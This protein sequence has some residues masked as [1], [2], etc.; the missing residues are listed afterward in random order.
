M[1]RS[2]V[3]LASLFLSCVLPLALEAQPEP[4]RVE[5]LADGVFA[6]IRQSPF[7]GASDANV[8][9][10]VN[11]EDVVVV[12]AN[13]FPASSREVIAEIRKRTSKPVRYL[14]NT[15]FHSD[16]HYGNA[17]YVKAFPGVEIISHPRT[18]ALVISE[19]IPALARNRATVYPGERDRL[20]GMLASGKR[21]DG[22]TLA[23]TDSQRVTELITLYDFFLSDTEGMPIVPATVTVSDS[24]VLHRGDR[25]IVVR[26]L[27]RGNTPG[28][29]VVHLPVERIL[30]TG[31]LVVSPTPFG[32]GSFLREW[33]ATLRSL[34]T[35]GATTIVPGH[36]DIMTDWRY[37][38]RLIPMFES[39]WEQVQRSVA[40]GADLEAT[41]K[42]VDLAPFREQFGAGVPDG[43]RAFDRLF[44]TPIVEAAFK[45]AKSA[46]PPRST[47]RSPS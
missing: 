26:W 45:Q 35:L 1:T 9:I 3:R 5:P 8:L 46:L 27:G 6:V 11:Q 24:L 18:R 15:H 29:L 41:R 20:R 37:V 47:S 33:P 21:S 19:D 40:G 32:F 4:Y 43:Q 16:H 34:K 10:I 25:S 31:D 36:G 28:D 13:I 30:A 2:R 12:D 42:A 39:I 23:A 44:A 17:E 38:D 22:S 7:K 14:I